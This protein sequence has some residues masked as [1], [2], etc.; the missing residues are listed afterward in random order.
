MNDL[1]ILSNKYEH[2]VYDDNEDL[3]IENM[4]KNVIKRCWYDTE[5]FSSI[6]EIA[7]AIGLGTKSISYYARLLN[8]P[9]RRDLK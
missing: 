8:L 3:N 7:M 2:I 5:R 9:R 6:E 1:T 4:K